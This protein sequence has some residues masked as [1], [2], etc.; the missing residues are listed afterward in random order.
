[1]FIDRIYCVALL[2]KNVRTNLEITLVTRYWEK[3]TEASML[4]APKSWE[5]FTTEDGFTELEIKGTL[6]L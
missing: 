2:P 1:M 3:D 6:R 4:D 5:S